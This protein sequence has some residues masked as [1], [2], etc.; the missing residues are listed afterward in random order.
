MNQAAILRAYGVT[1]TPMKL[2]GGLKEVPTDKASRT[3]RL[4]VCFTIAE[5]TLIKPGTKIIY[6]RITRPD[7]VVVTKTRYDTFNFNGQ[8]IPYSLRE[9]LDY[10]GTASNICISWTKKDT[11]KAA[12]KGK[13]TVS[14]LC[15][16]KEIGQGSFDLK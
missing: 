12:M 13:Y 15:E 14:I 3:D 6:I 2:K 4:K 5:N 16:D 10:K 1:V 11:D 9:D 8:T 7:N